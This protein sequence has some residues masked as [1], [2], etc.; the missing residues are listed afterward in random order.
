MGGDYTEGNTLL[1][2]AVQCNGNTASHA[3]WHYA[4]WCLWGSKWDKIAWKGLAGFAGK[5]E[6]IREVQ[7]EA[8]RKGVK[9][10]MESGNYALLRP[11]VRAKVI[12][13][14]R[15][16]IERGDFPLLRPEVRDKALASSLR[17]QKRLTEQGAHS[18][19]NKEMRAE[20][21]KKDSEKCKAMF[22]EGKSPLQKLEIV[23]KRKKQSS[24]F[25]SNLNST[26]IECPH[27]GKTG[28]YV[29]M[30]RYHFENCKSI[31]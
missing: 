20:K 21:A 12:D 18:L 3:M 27:C 7:L 31:K 1:V 15:D 5:E 10:L 11:E 22:K 14:I 23:D 26:P 25:V 28:G 19:Q 16:M 13:S 8:S 24:K 6:I 4:N 9:S 29:N 17:T 30:K 2:D